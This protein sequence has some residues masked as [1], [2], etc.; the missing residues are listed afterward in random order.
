MSNKNKKNKAEDGLRKR[1]A[2]ATEDS[3]EPQ[4]LEMTQKK[5]EEEKTA[6]E[7]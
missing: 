6:A 2:G 1:G 3:T 4:E 7:Q 5:P